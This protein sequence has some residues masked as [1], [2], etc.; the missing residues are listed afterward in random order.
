[1]KSTIAY[2]SSISRMKYDIEKNSLINNLSRLENTVR[3]KFNIKSNTK[4]KDIDC[5]TS[6]CSFIFS[7]CE[8]IFL[9]DRFHK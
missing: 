4:L 9:V 5:Y 8:V 3:K 2:L 6:Q 1:M 7:N